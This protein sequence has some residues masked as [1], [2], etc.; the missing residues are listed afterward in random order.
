MTQEGPMNDVQFRESW[1][2]FKGALKQEWDKLTDA[3]IIEIDDDQDKF[4]NVIRMRYGERSGDVTKW[5]ERRYARWSGWY[6]G[7]QE[8]K[9]PS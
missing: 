4:T 5:M 7:Y 3:D 1:G 2:Q 8:K 6:E 9:S